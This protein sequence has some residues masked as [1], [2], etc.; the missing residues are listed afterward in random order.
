MRGEPQ[1]ADPR[2]RVTL[3]SG[4]G[5]LTIRRRSD[6]IGQLP[7][8]CQRAVGGLEGRHLG[9]EAA[10]DVVDPVDD[11]G[12]CAEVGAQ[13]EH[14]SEFFAQP[15]LGG[16]VLRD[17]GSTK[18]VDRLLRVADEEKPLRLRRSGVDAV[19]KRNEL[20]QLNLN[21][22]GVLEFV[23]QQPLVLGGQ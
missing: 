20:R 10:E 17:V 6:R 18:S 11:A 12:Q 7:S 2:P 16:S 4:A 14:Q 5:A 21:G 22:I 1:D 23:E 9:D 8:R 15:L 19:G 3:H 13:G